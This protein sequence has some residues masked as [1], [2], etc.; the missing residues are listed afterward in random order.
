MEGIYPI[1]IVNSRQAKIS[2]SIA[3]TGETGGEEDTFFEMNPGDSGTWKRGHMQVAMVYLHDAGET[4]IM[5]IPTGG[6]DYHIT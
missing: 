1:T 2:V 4:R 3:I 6:A 5:T